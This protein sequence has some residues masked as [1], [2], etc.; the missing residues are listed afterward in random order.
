MQQRHFFN[1][2]VDTISWLSSNK[3]GLSSDQAVQNLDRIEVVCNTLQ[4]YRKQH[5]I[6]FIDIIKWI[7]RCLARG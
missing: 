5:A 1:K 7:F 2:S 3:T 6:S 4:E